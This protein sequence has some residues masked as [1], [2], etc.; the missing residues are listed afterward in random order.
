MD[1]AKPD[2]NVETLLPKQHV[3]E[4]EFCLDFIRGFDFGQVQNDRE[5]LGDVLE[6]ATRVVENMQR[7]IQIFEFL[8]AI[9][10]GKRAENDNDIQDH[11]A[12]FEKELAKYQAFAHT[13]E[14]VREQ[15]V[16]LMSRPQ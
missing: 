15:L 10:V 8:G 13:V 3:R 5:N 9:E 4:Y 6:Q 16:R 2:F 11:F 1:A 12:V 14:M 7:L